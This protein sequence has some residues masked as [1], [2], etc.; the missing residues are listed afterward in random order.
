MLC[1][2]TQVLSTMVSIRAKG[3]K[4]LCM[5]I[6]NNFEGRVSLM[7]ILKVKL[8]LDLKKNILERGSLMKYSPDRKSFMEE[9]ETI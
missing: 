2:N 1:V 8:K 3:T 9:L 7:N 4:F 5:G 6:S